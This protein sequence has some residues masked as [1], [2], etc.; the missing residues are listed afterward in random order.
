[1]N[2]LKYPKMLI[3]I[4]AKKVFIDKMSQRIIFLDAF[5]AS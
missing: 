1:M 3:L 4:T 2:G 5:Q